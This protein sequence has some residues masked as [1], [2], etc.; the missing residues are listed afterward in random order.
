MGPENTLVSEIGLR[1]G[2]LISV[3]FLEE[4]LTTHE[5]KILKPN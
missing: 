4:R 2:L 1:W 3:L 5:S